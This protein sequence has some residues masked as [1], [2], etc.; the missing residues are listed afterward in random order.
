MH[1]GRRL[2]E[3]SRHGISP[4]TVGRFPFSYPAGSGLRRPGGRSLANLA[5]NRNRRTRPVKY[6]TLTDYGL[7]VAV[8]AVMFRPVSANSGDVPVM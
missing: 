6:Y 8:S 2:R 1:R 3:S 5:A 7:E 4:G